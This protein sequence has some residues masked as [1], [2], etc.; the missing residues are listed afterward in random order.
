MMQRTHERGTPVA[1]LIDAVKKYDGTPVV[2]GV[3]LEIPAGQTTMLVGPN[4]S[5]KTTSMEML[6]G[7]R[8]MSDGRAEIMGQAVQPG[9]PHRLVTGVQLQQSGL[10]SRLRVN[11]ALAAV[12]SLYREPED[13]RQL[14]DSLG[15]SK[16]W[17]TSVDKLSGGLRRRLDIAIACVG[18]PHFLLLDEP[19]SGIDPEGRAEL[20]EFLRVRA[21]SGC[22]ILASTHDLEEAEAFADRLYVMASGRIA[23]HGQPEEVLAA[24]GGQF[25]L[26]INDASS[27]LTQAIQASGL[28][29]GKV[30]I[31]TL[32]VGGADEIDALRDRLQ[33]LEPGLEVRFGRIRLEDVFAVT[34]WRDA[35]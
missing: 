35:A 31:T 16:H 15:L 17:R 26:R 21:R 2:N 5:G 13:I 19:T 10:P 25:R 9:G 14:A 32:A 20:W 1:Q 8:E 22:A 24:A 30:G 34:M 33:Q 11:E 6:I 28:V 27:Q 18:S 7:L 12:A 4:G 3:S 23:L 29:H